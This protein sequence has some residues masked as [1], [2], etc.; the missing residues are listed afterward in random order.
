MRHLF[1]DVSAWVGER[2]R[3]GASLA[4]G[5]S[6]AHLN[7]RRNFGFNLAKSSWLPRRK[8][9]TLTVYSTA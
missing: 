2:L 3:R 1:E 9:F 7:S 5:C 4:I 8:D 6:R